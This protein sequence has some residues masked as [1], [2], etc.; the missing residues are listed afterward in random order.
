M[1]KLLL[2]F[3]FI[4]L[5]K[6]IY[7]TPF[8]IDYT[9]VSTDSSFNY[10][11][12]QYGNYYDNVNLKLGLRAV[13]IPSGYS[14]LPVVVSP[15]VYGIT[16]SGALTYLYSI[17]SSTYYLYSSPT[18]YYYPNVFY[19]TP[20]YSGYVVQVYAQS[21]NV[22]SIYS[23]AYIYPVGAPYTYYYPVDSPSSPVPEVIGC[24][25]FFLSGQ[26][27]IYLQE[28]KIG[29]YNLYIENDASQTLN[30]FSV[31]TS[32]PSRLDIV[33]IDY[34][35]FVSG[36]SVGHINLRLQADTVGDD[37]SSSFD[38]Y[39][40]ARYGS[41]QECLKTYNVTYHIK[42]DESSNTGSCQD[43][44]LKD[45]T[46]TIND[47]STTRKTIAIEN[48]SNDYDY[49][50]ENIKIKN[51]ESISSRIITRPTRINKN[52][53]RNIEVDFTTDNLLHTTIRY[54]EMEVEGYLT[55]SG[56][57][58]KKCAKKQNLVITILDTERSPPTS[59]ITQ[60]CKDILIYTKNISQSEDSTRNYSIND[61][62]FVFNNSNQQFNISKITINDNTSNAEIKNLNYDYR[63]YTKSRGIIFFDLK[64]LSVNTTEY[65]RGTISVNGSFA[66]GKV[67]STTDIGVKQFDIS[68]LDSSDV[69]SNVGVYSKSVTSG[70]NQIFVY[71]NTNKKFYVNDVLFQ[72]RQG[73][74]A[75]IT[76]KQIVVE[77]NTQGT[78][79]TGISGNGR[80]EM[81]ISGRF[82]DG[83]TC[84]FNQTTS[85]ILTTDTQSI[86][87]SGNA[88]DYELV[89]PT[90]VSI[91][92]A[93]ETINLSF[94]N[95]SSRA[96]KIIISGNG[97]VTEPSVIF[98][99]GFDSFNQE[100]K[101]SNFDNPRA[102]YFDIMLNNCS[103]TRTT[104][105][106]ISNI[107]ERDRIFLVS[108]PTIISPISNTG[109][110]L[111][112]VNNSF[113][114]TK[115]ITLKLS[116]FPNNFL[117][118]E[119]TISI[120]S[121]SKKDV[122]LTI[123][124]PENAD[125]LKYNGYIELYSEKQLITKY[126]LVIDISPKIEQ[127]SITTTIEN[128]EK[129]YLVKMNIKNNSP[130]AQETTIDFGLDVSFVIEGDKEVKLLPNE[131]IT[132]HY[133][134][135]SSSILK[136]DIETNVQIKDKATNEILSKEKII[137]KTNYS[138][139][140]GFL[141]FGNIGLIFF[142]LIILIVFIIIFRKK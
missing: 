16:S 135:I 122:S 20:D 63:V 14:Y 126:P 9:Y 112:V 64:T 47:N 129:I 18:I 134:I 78:L 115:N 35:D 80:L 25:S 133:R 140:T 22:Y 139:I 72:N 92:N 6:T 85:G 114:E 58:D 10:L 54:L 124:I 110:V 71:N 13:N 87:L 38:I 97:L 83:K 45:T 127:I 82:D 89:V 4:L 51:R 131:E 117:S 53:T 43:I 49:R 11:N 107:S 32:N 55:R 94:N 12:V 138:A 59:T 56:R 125:K 100:I 88:C 132:K 60:N 7:S 137:L 66:D 76:S 93:I 29:N 120:P 106:V 69:C 81:L 91:N 19:I 41:G 98:L 39:V 136:E 46:F 2:V 33:E 84:G 116:G 15:K 67:C 65:S 30:V 142:G 96:G 52:S 118:S 8:A 111:T 77:P 42:D 5:F 23:S 130:I 121:Q 128:Q 3:C 101:L 27:D 79:N 40:R 1:K 90:T 48:S 17:P 26:R 74:S 44:S 119:R 103:T 62:F 108:Y 37:Y 57:T 61:G 68:V 70:N 123:V 141:I 73:L 36:N 113:S 102:I 21:G 50:I 34:P 28:D 105:T 109:N 86:N 99:R 24:T 31:T 95:R 104:T 75:N